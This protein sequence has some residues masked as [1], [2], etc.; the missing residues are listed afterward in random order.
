MPPGYQGRMT[1]EASPSSRVEGFRAG[2][3]ICLPFSS[4]STP[5]SLIQGAKDITQFLAADLWRR[6]SPGCG[7]ARTS[8]HGQQFRTTADAA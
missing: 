7:K 1:C 4:A 8:G 5:C 3:H 2:I 6:T